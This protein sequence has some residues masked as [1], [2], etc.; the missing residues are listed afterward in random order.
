MP[1]E[2]ESRVRKF[3]SRLDAQIRSA[4]GLPTLFWST[5]TELQITSLQGT[6]L[7]LLNLQPDAFKG[8][9]LADCFQRQGADRRFIDAHLRALEGESCSLEATWGGRTLDARVEPLRNADGMITGTIGVAREPAE[10]KR[11]A[12]TPGGRT[13]EALREA[14]EKYRSIIENAVEGIF[15]TTPEG[16][17][18]SVNPALARMY[19]Y[20]SPEELMASV[21]DIGRQVYVDPGRRAEFKRLMEEHGVVR[22][23]QY[24]VYRRDAKK[25]WLSESARAV[26]DAH[27]TILYYEGSVEDITE[28]KRAETE[29]QVMFEIIRGV[30]VTA[31]LDEL[32]GLIHQS[33]RKVLYA[34]NCFVALYDRSTGMF[35]FPFFVDQFDTAPPPVKVGKSC[36]AY[37]FRTGRPMLIT[38]KEFDQ[39]AEQGEVE[40]VGT[41]SPTWLGVPL[42]TPLEMIGVLVVQHYEDE[43]A[44]TGR[45]LEFLASVGG[46]IALAIQRNQAEDALRA[47]ENRLRAIIETEPE[48]VKLVACDGTLLDMN[49][50]GLAMIEAES[51][52]PLIGKSIY[53]LVCPEYRE[54]F[55]TFTESVCQGHRGRIEFEIT[56]L[57]GTRRWMETYAVPLPS[58]SDAPP[59]LLGV[60]RDITERKRAEE[61]LRQSEASFRLL[62][63]HNP[64]PTW[65]FDLETLRFLQV[66]DAAVAHYGYS[67]EEFLQMRITD[68][69]PPEDVPRLLETAKKN[70]LGQLS[71][72][73]WRHR[74][75]DG[76]IV[77]V[78]IIWHR[79]EFDG[80]EIA[81]VVA[82]DVTERQ[83]AEEALR[84]SEANYR[85]LVQGAPYGIY[86]AGADGKLL[87]V[88]PALVDML[89]YSSEAELIAVNLDTDVYRDPGERMR[90]LRQH[91]ER[92]AGVEVAWKR[93]DATPITVRLSGRLVRDPKGSTDYYE[94]I[95]ENVTEQR[96]LE[97]QLRQAQKMEAVGRLAGGV[98]HDFNNLLMVIKGHTELL[99]E[100]RREE[101][102]LYRKAEQI[103]KAADR[104]AGLTRQ[105]LAFSRMQVLQP[106]V[107]DLN[108][109][110]TEMGKMLPRLIGEDIQLS[111]VTN[112]KLGR[113]KADPGQ[114][115]QVILNL[116]VN[117][118]D[119]MPHGGRIVIETAN[120]ELD[121]AYA[122]R[123]PPMQPGRFVMLAVS[124]TGT[125]MDVE[126]QTH[127]FEPFFTTKEKGKGTGLGLATVYGVVKQ[128]GGFIWLYS[129]PGQGTTFKIYLPRVEDAVE[130][131]RSEKASAESPQGSETI[132]LVED[133]QDVREVAR[134]F[135]TLG[136]YAVL[137][138]KDGAEAIE[139]AQ[140]HPGPIH[141][142]VTD[143]VMPGISGRKL[144][145]RLA[146]L[147][148]QMKVVYMSGYTE[149][150]TVRQ[151]DLDQNAA[152]LTKPF[153][154]STLA[155]TVREVLQGSKIR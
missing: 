44:Y 105:L 102:W 142:L 49:P 144:A 83:R 136:G 7:A 153:T 75:K 4:E 148:P 51:L 125:G 29:R 21:S 129:E 74:Y 43:A 131:A 50:A 18:L 147:R 113:V 121:E 134:E 11:P 95:A 13:Q 16:G 152:L 118:R 155:R 107:I 56:G 104:A 57:K 41:P 150:A 123:H 94:M 67:R 3:S 52:T 45:D 58:D 146:T 30:N 133:E 10:S 76:R 84:R 48:C 114:M 2:S 99:L 141:L 154:R 149:Y 90:I 28:R 96:A 47:S 17:Y 37:V 65:V 26:R 62:F 22:D 61:A 103:H 70:R 109:V 68:I 112:P 31:N 81:L 27:G 85:S 116:V 53:P 110:V 143:M 60:T 36:T 79:L 23:F 55:R 127:I 46:Q 93:R 64:M 54:T 40:L 6:G 117:A 119:A 69:R 34:E 5:D 33:L 77:N 15:Q 132:L 19:G 126:T 137:E 100:G 14:E 25:I 78:E 138:A 139:T 20:D 108:A 71:P 124:D 63:Q 73:Q 151:G 135:L 72:S 98:A 59:M 106:R 101:D 92:L 115:E 32:L 122:R 87:D 140:R 12:S 130:S 86:R 145:A 120:C 24:Q 80:R 88:N 42:R 9:Y 97:H 1:K 38:Q 8:V 66:N 39:L 82:Q 91:P 89:G 35:H 128:T 111:I